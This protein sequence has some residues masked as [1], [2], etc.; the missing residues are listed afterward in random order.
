[1][2]GVQCETTILEYN[3]CTAASC[4]T[5][6]IGNLSVFPTTE[7]K[8]TSD[9]FRRI[10]VSVYFVINVVYVWSFVYPQIYSGT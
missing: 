1:M 2:A 6:S 7:Y 9:I 4:S 8:P 5:G 10:C 3:P